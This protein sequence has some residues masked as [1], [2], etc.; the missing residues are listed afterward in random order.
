[1]RWGEKLLDLGFFGGLDLEVG[2][3]KRRDR[4]ERKLKGFLGRRVYEKRWL[5]TCFQM[6]SFL[7]VQNDV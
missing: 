3:A 2:V 6:A 1:V 7:V 4:F 5:Y